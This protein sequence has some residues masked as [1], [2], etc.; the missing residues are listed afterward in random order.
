M[1][2]ENKNN[3]VDEKTITFASSE[4]IYRMFV[5][6]NT[7]SHL[8]QVLEAKLNDGSS[9]GFD[10]DKWVAQA[11]K[12]W[13]NLEDAFADGDIEAHYRL[14]QK[15]KRFAL[16]LFNKERAQA[17][18]ESL[19]AEVMKQRITS[20]LEKTARA[21]TNLRDELQKASEDYV[22]YKLEI[23]NLQ[24]EELRSADAADSVSQAVDAGRKKLEIIARQK[25]A[26]FRQHEIKL[27]QKLMENYLLFEKEVDSWERKKQAALINADISNK[28]R[29]IIEDH[30]SL[31][32]SY[33]ELLSSA[34]IMTSLIKERIMLA[35]EMYDR[36]GNPDKVKKGLNIL[37]DMRAT[38]EKLKNMYDG[39]LAKNT[40][41]RINQ[42]EMFTSKDKDVAKSLVEDCE[43][44]K[45]DLHYRVMSRR[46]ELL[47]YS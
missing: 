23:S 14:D 11:E 22:R 43:K 5:D 37:E 10:I 27:A 9:K 6:E 44:D 17:Y 36:F 7:D 3:G 45:K 34:E 16:K 29:E 42:H 33:K 30:F 18:E 28:R 4:D 13:R 21:L 46:S 19:K 32:Y 15:S 12:S 20:K 40:K 26:A 1:K 31:V 47:S 39:I 25:G 8:N 41:H 35:L 24:L 38:R 2:K